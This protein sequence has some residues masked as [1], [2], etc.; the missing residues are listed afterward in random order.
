[1]RVDSLETP[2]NQAAI[3]VRGDT[4]AGL[5]PYKLNIGTTNGNRPGIVTWAIS[6][7]DN[8]TASVR[9]TEPMPLGQTV[10]IAGTLAGD[11]G[12]LRLYLDGVLTSSSMTDVRPFE[13]LDATRE[14]ALWIG[15]IHSNTIFSFDGL[16]DEVRISDTALSPNNFLYQ[17][18]P[19]PNAALLMM[20]GVTLFAAVT[21]TTRAE[22]S[23]KGGQPEQP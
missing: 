16:I 23:L 12:E 7:A 11:T 2:Q 8:R 3:V 15:S 18:V 17:A 22:Q 13:K 9:S 10:H 21:R 5:D 20:C 6:D 19:E 14:P 4:R 1:M